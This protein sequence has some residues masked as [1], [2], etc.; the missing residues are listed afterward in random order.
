MDLHFAQPG[1]LFLL[2][3]VPLVGLW[4]ALLD[5]ARECALAAFMA[6]AMQRKLRPAAARAR[7]RWQGGLTLAGLALL[8]VAAARPQWG[9]REEVV[10]R[11]AR[12]VV[13]ALDVSRSMLA[14]D[15]HPNRLARAKAD[16]L[17]LIRDLRGDRAALV[18][19]RHKAVLV[20]P[21]TTD[22]AFL[23]QALDG[24]EPDSAPRGETDIGD[25][26][27]KALD[28]FDT[29]DAAH[30]A[31]ILISDGEDLQDTARA[32]AARA[33]ERGIPIF[34]V[35]IGS[36]AGTTI[37]DAD[38]PGGVAQFKGETVTTRLNHDA[39][40]AIARATRGV[41]IPIER[42]STATTT[43]GTLYRDH[44]RQIAAR[45]L[46]ETLAR[47]RIERYTWFLLPSFLCLLGAAA[48]SR[49]RLAASPAGTGAPAPAPR[50]RARNLNPPSR[51][52]KPL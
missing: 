22:T 20:C 40:L 39:L 5:R 51:E 43:L 46:E 41:Y 35:G 45:D 2:W 21:L 12:D 16:V 30:K 38:A 25:A 52:L 36:R 44:L 11:R 24:I 8:L 27:V 4:W 42:A 37:P 50:A 47:R 28:A 49:G 48:L 34:T 7:M 14:R 19:F 23:L 18:A 31:I 15:V 13:I 10:F 3:L 1:V 17:D 9:L 32:A 33:A 6:P 26:I 29:A